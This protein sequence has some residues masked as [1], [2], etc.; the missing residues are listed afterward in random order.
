MARSNLGEE[1]SGL[2]EKK[3]RRHLWYSCGE[4]RKTPILQI[5]EKKEKQRRSRRNIREAG[6]EKKKK[7]RTD[8]PF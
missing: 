8:S 2:K 6:E 1:K 5:A 7:K 4:R 3:F